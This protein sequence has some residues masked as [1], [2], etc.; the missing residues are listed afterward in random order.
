MGSLRWVSLHVWGGVVAGPDVHQQN[1]GGGENDSVAESIQ[2]RDQLKIGRN[3]EFRRRRKNHL[4]EDEG[5]SMRQE[6]GAE[7]SHCETNG[8]GEVA[9]GAREAIEEKSCCQ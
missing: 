7:S 8:K 9:G 2:E 5:R 1:I 4:H 3:C 6:Y